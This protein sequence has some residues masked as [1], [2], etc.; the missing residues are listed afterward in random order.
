MNILSFDPTFLQ[1]AKMPV[2]L[3]AFRI[4]EVFN[5]MPYDADMEE[6]LT[7]CQEVL[8]INR[9]PHETLDEAKRRAVYQLAGK[10]STPI[11]AHGQWTGQ[12]EVADLYQKSNSENFVANLSL[13]DPNTLILSQTGSTSK[14]KSTINILTYLHN[15]LRKHSTIDYK[16][17]ICSTF[18]SKY[19]TLEDTPS[20]FRGRALDKLEA[21]AKVLRDCLH[22]P[23]PNHLAEALLTEEGIK[24][25][26]EIILREQQERRDAAVWGTGT[27]ANDWGQ[28]AEMNY[29]Q[30]NGGD[31][32]DD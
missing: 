13:D 3:R 14:E 10:I 15:I 8:T 9:K 12:C 22:I 18:L 31:W 28:D 2:L 29:M 19:I 7:S 24:E 20:L 1:P 5:L 21:P 27:S 30:G 16:R 23:D 11:I 26:R 6:I 4:T 17:R 25:R 32:M